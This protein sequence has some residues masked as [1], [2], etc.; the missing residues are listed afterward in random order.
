MRIPLRKL[1]RWLGLNSDM[2]IV[3]LS[4]PWVHFTP[5]ILLDLVCLVLACAIG[6]INIENTIAT[7]ERN[8]ETTITTPFENQ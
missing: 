6:V 7:Q 1:L 8:F 2:P 4:G 5:M 3:T